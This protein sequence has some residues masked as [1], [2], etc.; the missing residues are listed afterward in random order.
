M[1][2]ALF[3]LNCPLCG[4]KHMMPV[5]ADKHGS[6]YGGACDFCEAR[7]FKERALVLFVRRLATTEPDGIQKGEWSASKI[8]DFVKH[9]PANAI[10]L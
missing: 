2:T 6:L 7:V 9:H 5:R 4:K 8:A 1:K 10:E 3:R